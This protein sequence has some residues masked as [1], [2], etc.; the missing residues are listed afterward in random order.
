MLE[1]IV[2]K[3]K[4]DSLQIPKNIKIK[5]WYLFRQRIN[6]IQRSFTVIVWYAN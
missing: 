6:V 3:N 4:I 2:D 1:D 5:A